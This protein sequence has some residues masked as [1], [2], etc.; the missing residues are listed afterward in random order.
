MADP[1]SI[2]LKS[3]TVALAQL[4]YATISVFMWGVAR[5]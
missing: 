4:K 3:H 2:N 1:I 5:L